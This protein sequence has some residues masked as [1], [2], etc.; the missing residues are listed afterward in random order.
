MAMAGSR[1]GRQPRG[2]VDGR[3]AVGAADDADGRGF[4]G[5]K[6]EQQ[7]QKKRHHD[8]ELRAR[9][10]EKA[11]RPRQERPKVGHR[12]D[13]QEDQRRVDA[14]FYALV[15]V[16]QKPACLFPGGRA[17]EVGQRQVGQ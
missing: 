7:R 11:R 9:A 13:A 1:W 3:R 14:Q 6:A 8:A 16:V 17:H 12:A 10:H 5:I 15:Q 2:Q 4:L